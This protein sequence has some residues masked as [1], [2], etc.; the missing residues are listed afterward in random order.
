LFNYDE[1]GHMLFRKVISIFTE[2]PQWYFAISATFIIFSIFVFIYKYSP[3]IYLSVLL[4]V[5]IGGYFTSHNITRQYIAIAICLYGF[6]YIIKRNP[7]KY[8]LVVL[9][10]I[11][12]HTSSIIMMP[13]YLLAKIPITRKLIFL[14]L[15]GSIALALSY[16]SIF[17]FVHN[18]IYT[19]S[20][21]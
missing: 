4:F 17:P 21:I 5:T 20:Y 19:D 6:S 8:F 16:N 9:V 2:N 3:N 11:S 18:I 14:Y 12:F 13:L 10:A 1:F 15:V 7:I